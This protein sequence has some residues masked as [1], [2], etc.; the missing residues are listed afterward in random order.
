MAERRIEVVVDVESKDV[1]FAT[2]RVLSLQQQIRL[3]SK[4]I[5]NVDPS[6]ES[7]K[8]LSKKLNDT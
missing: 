8:V 5:Q 2:D 4:E 6:S 3:L 7:F 1:Q